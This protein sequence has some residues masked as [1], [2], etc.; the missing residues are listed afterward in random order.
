MSKR[1]L[2]VKNCPKVDQNFEKDHNV[3][4][5]FKIDQNIDSQ[6]FVKGSECQKCEKMTS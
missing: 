4:S 3:E 5:L 6:K 2:K 1:M